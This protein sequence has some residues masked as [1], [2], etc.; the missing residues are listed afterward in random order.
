MAR[1]IAAF[2]VVLLLPVCS[3][4]QLSVDDIN[5]LKQQAIDEGWTFEVTQN[6]ATE[7]SLDQ[8]CGLVEPPDWKKNARFVDFASTKDL[9][10]SFDWRDQGLPVVKNQ[11]GCG[12]CWAFATVG[13]LECN[14]ML[15]DGIE[16]NLSEQFLVSC[17]SSGWDC[18]GGWFAHDYHQWHSGPCGDTGAVME[19]DFP[20]VAWDA[21]CGCPYPS[22]EYVIH[23]WA[24]IGSSGGVPPES[25][26]K[27]AILDYGPV[28]VAVY[29]NGAMQSYGGGVFN[30]CATG[31]INHAVTLVGWDDTD[32]PGVWIMR[33]S[34]GTGWGEDGGYMRIPYY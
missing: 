29:A 19:A 16:V 21:P 17:N 20:Y 6:P 26:I 18:G 27:Q 30:G 11:G 25:Y 28:S 13:P 23:D 14:I 5:N 15:Q 33:N 12:S 22:R 3:F 9:P 24:Y 34:W 31:T 8:L 4:A 2:L 1:R 7:Y 32:G 10:P